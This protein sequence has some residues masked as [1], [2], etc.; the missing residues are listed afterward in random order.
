MYSHRPV[1]PEVL[2]LLVAEINQRLSKADNAPLAQVEEYSRGTQHWNWA[3][4]WQSK[5]KVA[6]VRM[7]ADD[8]SVRIN[9]LYLGKSTDMKNWTELLY[10]PDEPAWND[11]ILFL[12]SLGHLE[13]WKIKVHEMQRRLEAMEK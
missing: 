12:G 10:H 5:L 7:Y 13:Y 9:F 3:F 2:D 1:S 8:R 6:D 4:L 11:L